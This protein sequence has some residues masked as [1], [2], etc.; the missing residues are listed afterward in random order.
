MPKC[1]SYSYQANVQPWQNART[2][3]EREVP[4]PTA[5]ELAHPRPLHRTMTPFTFRCCASSRQTSRTVIPH[6]HT[7]LSYPS[8]TTLHQGK[9]PNQECHLSARSLVAF[10]LEQMLSAI[11]PFFPACTAPYGPVWSD[12]IS[13]PQLSGIQRGCTLNYPT[14]RA[15]CLLVMLVLDEV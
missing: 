3:D 11:F 8:T 2:Q 1:L 15:S 12:L 9:L 10:S 14:R 7:S 5:S 13:C 4:K 6:Q